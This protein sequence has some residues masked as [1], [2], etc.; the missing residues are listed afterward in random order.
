MGYAGRSRFRTT[1]GRLSFY[2]A[3]NVIALAVATASTLGDGSLWVS[4][5][6]WAIAVAGALAI[7]EAIFA[8]VEL[9][10]E[11]PSGSA[12]TARESAGE[13][14]IQRIGIEI[15]DRGRARAD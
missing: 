4:V 15:L 6:C 3:L 5:A 7:V 14:A 11:V 12:V 13:F 1:R 2:V 9:G 10:N 8:Y